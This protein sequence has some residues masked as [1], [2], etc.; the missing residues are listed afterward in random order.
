MTDV[1]FQ[2]CE[3]GLRVWYR[4]QTMESQESRNAE[5]L[6]RM[7][8]WFEGV[9]RGL[10]DEMETLCLIETGI[11]QLIMTPKHYM[12]LGGL[13]TS[14]PTSI[15]TLDDVGLLYID[16]IL[17]DGTGDRWARLANVID[18]VTAIKKVMHSSTDPDVVSRISAMFTAL[19]LHNG[20][21]LHTSILCA[22]EA[23]M[24]RLQRTA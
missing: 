11:S 3:F 15:E 23:R 19:D 16:R 2:F 8:K 1:V 12:I 17:K 7:G 6:L 13:K 4:Y 24:A 5:W 18:L 21:S 14:A 10:P 9:A 22:H 20:E